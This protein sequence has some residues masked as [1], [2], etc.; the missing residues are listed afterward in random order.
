MIGLRSIFQNNTN[1]FQPK[2]CL[3]MEVEDT[4]SYYFVHMKLIV[5]LKNVQH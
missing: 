5:I 1:M 2:T 3:E 4:T